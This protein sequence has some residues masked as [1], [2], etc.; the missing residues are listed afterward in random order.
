MVAAA[1]CLLF[2]RL[3]N[4]LVVVAVK[5]VGE[6]IVERKGE[7]RGSKGSSLVGVV[8]VVVVVVGGGGGCGADGNGEVGGGKKDK[9]SFPLSYLF[10]ASHCESYCASDGGPPSETVGGV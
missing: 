1:A 3:N 2:L 7:G 10:F 9:Y 5:V 6:T 4:D 8:V